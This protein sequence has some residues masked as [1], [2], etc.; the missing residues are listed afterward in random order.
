MKW[1]LAITI[2]LMMTGLGCA[3]TSQSIESVPSTSLMGSPAESATASVERVLPPVSE[4]DIRVFV[5]EGGAVV[6]AHC[7]G[8]HVTVSR[9][10]RGGEVL[11]EADADLMGAPEGSVAFIESVD[12]NFD[13]YMD[14]LVPYS[15]GAHNMSHRAWVWNEAG[16]KFD[17]VAEFKE[18]GSWT[19]KPELK[20]L[21]VFTHVSAVEYEESIWGIEGNLLSRKV[22]VHVSPTETAEG[23]FMVEVIRMV[24]GHES[25]SVTEHSEAE[26]TKAVKEAL[27]AL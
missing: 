8:E 13:G 10:D 14:I 9:M 4:G 24:D 15:V 20:V 7:V 23:R 22:W 16:Q 6:D 1:L 18:L 19:V 26:L 27:A 21:H 2:G 17:E 3:G 5:H 25:R 11:F 12:I